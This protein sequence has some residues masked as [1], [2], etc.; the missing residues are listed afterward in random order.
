MPSDVMWLL[1][2]PVLSRVIRAC[3]TE[4]KAP[5]GLVQAAGRKVVGVEGEREGGCSFRALRLLRDNTQKPAGPITAGARAHSV[6]PRAC[7]T[8]HNIPE[9]TITAEQAIGYEKGG[10]V[11]HL[12]GSTGKALN[13][14]QLLKEFRPICVT[15]LRRK[16]QGIWTGL[17]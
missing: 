17:G 15:S 8:K 2:K 3:R 7:R 16:P 12:P 9:E 4:F 5:E 10:S 13:S 6:I 1:P 14:F 11:F